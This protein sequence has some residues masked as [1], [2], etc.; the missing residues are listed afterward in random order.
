MCYHK[1]Q[2][3]S[4]DTLAAYYQVRYSTAIAEQ[5][6]I[7]FHESGFAHLAGPVITLE[8]PEDIQ[9]MHWG[10]IPWWVKSW[11]DAKGLRIK[12]LNCISEEM[13]TKA[14]F[15]DSVKNAKRCLIPCTGFYEWQH[16]GKEKLPH[17]IYLKDQ[18][19][20]S[21]AG[22]YSNWTDKETGKELSTYTVLTTAANELMEQIHNSKKRMPVIIPG[23]HEKDWLSDGLKPEDVSALCR[24]LDAGL[25]QAHRI[26]KMIT[27]RKIDN[28]NVPE[29]SKRMD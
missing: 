29:I 5:A 28:K 17:Y 21:L 14:S 1:S 3:A 27:D 19:L 18:P 6:Q 4:V 24:P 11:N 25:M 13:A 26:S 23:D 16:V 20:F 9:L 22:L 15:R 10:L 7:R 8:A 2:T 12:T